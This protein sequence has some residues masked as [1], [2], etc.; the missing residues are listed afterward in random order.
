MPILT[1][2][3]EAID[4]NIFNCN[5]SGVK[6]EWCDS[7]KSRAAVTYEQR[8]HAAKQTYMR[9]SKAWFKNRT[10]KNFVEAILVRIFGILMVL[11]WIKCKFRIYN[12][13]EQ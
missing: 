11:S 1:A 10:R 2:V 6:L 9:F 3:F 12:K 4:Q 13:I 7:L 8:T 5:L